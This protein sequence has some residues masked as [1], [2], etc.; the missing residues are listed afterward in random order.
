MLVAHET[1]RRSSSGLLAVQYVRYL[2]RGDPLTFI[3]VTTF[4]VL[5]AAMTLH[6]CNLAGAVLAHAAMNTL[7]FVFI[8]GRVSSL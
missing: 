5:A 4:G 3:L 1:L 2:L 7:I 8:G 6:H